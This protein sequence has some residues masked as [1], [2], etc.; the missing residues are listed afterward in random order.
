MY[1]Q[2]VCTVISKKKLRK[3]IFFFGTLKITYKNNRIRIRGSTPLTNGSWCGSGSCYFC[4][5]SGSASGSISRRCGSAD[6]HPD[7]YKNFMDPQHWLEVSRGA[8]GAVYSLIFTPHKSWYSWTIQ[9]T[10]NGVYAF[11]FLFMLP[12]L[13]LNYKLKSVAHLPW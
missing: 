5:R 10:V 3:K 1:L 2:K 8:G 7:P 12:Q 9:T 4:K 11:G 6:P 13:F